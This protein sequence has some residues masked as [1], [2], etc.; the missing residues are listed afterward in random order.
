MR[1]SLLYSFIFLS[2]FWSCFDDPKG[3]TNRARI[4]DRPISSVVETQ[5]CTES[6][7]V[8]ND[9]TKCFQ[10]TC[11][12]NYHL[13]TSQTE[14]NNVI[15]TYDEDISPKLSPEEDTKRRQNFFRARGLCNEGATPS[16]PTNEINIVDDTCVCQN[17]ATL[18]INSCATICAA[19]GAD[20]NAT[21]IINT[22][23]SAAILNDPRFIAGNGINVGTLNSWCNATIDDGRTD[24]A[25]TVQ[26][27]NGANTLVLSE[28]LK[29]EQQNT[30]SVTVPASLPDNTTYLGRIVESKSGSNA[31]S[32]PFQFRLKR[33]LA[34][35]TTVDSPLKIEPMT[36]YSC[37]FRR[38]T[39]ASENVTSSS[40]TFAFR[41]SMFDKLAKNP[42]PISD[43]SQLTIFC[44]DFQ[45]FGKTDNSSYPR[46][47]S[48]SHIF[49]LW[50]SDDNRFTN[51]G[52]GLE[53]NNLIHRRILAEYGQVDTQQYFAPFFG[54]SNG[55]RYHPLIQTSVIQGYI[56]TAF[57]D[58]SNGTAY[59]PNTTHYNSTE[60]KFKILKEIIGVDTEGL[61]MAVMTPVTYTSIATDAEPVTNVDLI[62]IRESI[63]NQIWFY[64][65]RNS[66]GVNVNIVPTT[67]TSHTKN[68]KFYWPP[69]FSNPTGRTV[70]SNGSITF[71]KKLWQEEYQILTGEE[72]QILIESA[73]GS[74]EDGGVAEI[75]STFRTSDKR[76]GCIPKE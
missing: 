12:A 54:G 58:D 74:N 20:T 21:L 34:T 37:I 46:L 59:C 32:V 47:E 26:I 68:L 9:G 64:T 66:S 40:Y 49:S 18:S 73:T 13:V 1:I 6:Q 67:E 5:I 14:L 11:P 48:F 19:R 25:C 41:L 10:G 50:D 29:F 36:M 44:H 61:F 24:P 70:A 53:I 23:P 75:P 57:Q 63:A 45:L 4:A 15:E 60:P 31:K 8:S 42:V 69:D 35:T 16:R 65:E 38:F 71:E 72:A 22:S 56:L 51:Q 28:N 39:K 62:Y 17:R 3:T 76:I 55:A 2:M 33:D 52:N 30:I 7:Y 27:Y 43:T